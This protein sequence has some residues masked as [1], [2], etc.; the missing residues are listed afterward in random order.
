[1][2]EILLS[3]LTEAT[4]DGTG[5]FDVLM[6]ATKGHL[7]EEYKKNRIKGP[8]YSSVY[9][10]SIE[11]ILQQSVLF[12]L[13][14]DKSKYEADLI[15]AQIKQMEAQVLLTNAQT[16]L[17]I[18]Q[19]KNAE[20]EWLLLA[21]QKAKLT[22]ETELIGQQKTNLEATLPQI[23]EQTKLVS[24]Q[25]LNA[26]AEVKLTEKQL[27]KLNA[28][29]DLTS[30]QVTNLAA[31]LPQILEQTKLIE[32]QRLNAI[33]EQE[34]NVLQKDKITAETVLVTQ[35]KV[36]LTSTNLQLLE[37]TK[38]IERQRLNAITEQEV[39]EKQKCKLSAEFDLLMEQKVK[40]VNESSLLAQKVQTEKAQ[41]SGVGV[42]EDS[43]IGKQKMLYQAQTEGFKRNAE[44][45]AAK[46]LVDSWTTRRISDEGTVADSVNKL[47]DLTVG[48]AVEKMMT[49]VGA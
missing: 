17:A 20:N 3:S 47:N 19:K 42:A 39:M 46:L 35:Q 15:A 37:Q 12:L 6:T 30:Q 5:V 48:R 28:D 33:V 7:D 40:T 24:Q 26:E 43:V 2:T 16:E 14:K 4:L 44:Q 34:I 8:E 29:I 41:T 25:V 13:S 31:T 23:V 1:M 38:L 9:L 21:E 49:G 18:Q 36:N 27:D 22:A 10:G 32:Q 45:S 11:A